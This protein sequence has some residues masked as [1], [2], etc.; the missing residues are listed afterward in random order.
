MAFDEG[1]Y[2]EPSL[3]PIKIE[4]FHSKIEYFIKNLLDLM[5][6]VK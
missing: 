3:F 5:S 4:E 1:D 6:Y 2:V